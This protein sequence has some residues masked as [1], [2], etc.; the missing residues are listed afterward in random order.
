ME[1]RAITFRRFAISDIHGCNKTL[2]ALLDKL[3]LTQ[4]DTIFFLGDYIDRGNDSWGVLKTITTLSCKTVYLKGNHEALMVNYCKNPIEDA[5]LW[6][7][8]GGR[9]T[10]QSIPWGETDKWLNW[11]NDLP[12]YHEEPDYFLVHAS[13]SS[14]GNPFVEDDMLWSRWNH[15]NMGKPIINGHTPT[16]LDKMIRKTG[17]VT[18]DGG[19]VFKAHDGLGNLVAYCLDT[20]KLIIQENVEEELPCV[21]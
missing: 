16:H 13:F 2:N 21:A 9:K 12:Y 20:K 15:P 4:K 10:R 8:N 5:G 11:I 1:T 19:C 3:H 14:N 17:N 18:I 6:F 7:V